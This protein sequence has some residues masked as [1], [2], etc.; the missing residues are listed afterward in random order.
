MC[1]VLVMLDIVF[2]LLIV[3]LLESGEHSTDTSEDHGDSE[4]SSGQ[5]SSSSGGLASRST[6][7]SQKDNPTVMRDSRAA[8]Q[9]DLSSVRKKYRG[10]TEV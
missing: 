2:K 1:C 4:E 5:P 9:V 6:H 3:L 7:F 8:A 10:K